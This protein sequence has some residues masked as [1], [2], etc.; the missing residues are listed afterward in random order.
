MKTLRNCSGS[1]KN[2]IQRA[3]TARVAC[4]AILAFSVVPAVWGA[5]AQ[6]TISPN[7]LKFGNQLVGTTSAALTA[8]LTNGQ[9]APLSITNIAISGP[10]SQINNC[11]L[12]LAANSNCTI[13]VRFSPIAVGTVS[14]SL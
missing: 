9:N 7:T 5:P 13:T 12:S 11:G 8:T 3:A 10:F 2:T 6:V 14:G 4:A 1:S